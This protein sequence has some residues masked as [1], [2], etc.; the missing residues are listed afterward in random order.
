MG[1]EQHN[2]ND[3]VE[4][5]RNNNVNDNVREGESLARVMVVRD[6]SEYKLKEI[7]EFLFRSYKY[8]SCRDFI[9]PAMQQI[10]KFVYM[11]YTDLDEG[12]RAVI[13][14]MMLEIDGDGSPRPYKDY[15]NSPL[16]KYTSS[17]IKCSRG[18]TCEKCGAKLPPN[19][20]VV[21]HKS[22]E[23]IGSELQYQND[24]QLLC[25]YCHMDTHGIRRTK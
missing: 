6:I 5:K 18:Y 16:W 19:G 3:N 9:N 22:Y 12:T 4:T 14:G 7:Q 13:L 8:G 1:N 17:H 23:H 10:D 15:T 21:H 11:W 2:V 20:L 24:V 25:T